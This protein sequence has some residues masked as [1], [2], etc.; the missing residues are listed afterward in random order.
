MGVL[1]QL[2]F[3]VIFFKNK[4]TL[5]ILELKSAID[6][7]V[8]IL[9]YQPTGVVVPPFLTVCIG[10]DYAAMASRCF[11]VNPPKAILH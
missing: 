2:V 9:N 11:G 7:I 3:D 8:L 1:N 6:V 4:A 5:A 10:R